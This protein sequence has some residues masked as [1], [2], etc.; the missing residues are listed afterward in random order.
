MCDKGDQRFHKLHCIRRKCENCGTDGLVAHYQEFAE[1]CGGLPVVYSKLERVKKLRKQKE[2]VQIMPVNHNTSITGLIIELA[3][4]LETLAEHIFVAT[5][6]QQQFANLL[7]EIPPSWV[8]LNMDFSENYSCIAQN[9]VQSAHWGH[10]QVTIHPT[11]AYYKCQHDNCTETVQEAL[12]F[13][14]SDLI[15]DSSAVMKFTAV[16]N[17]HLSQTRGITINRE[18]QLTDGCAAQY[19][20][21]TPFCDLSHAIEDFGFPIERHYY[22]SRHGKGPSDGAG[23]VVK[24]GTRR[25]VL[26][27]NVVINCAKDL[28]E[29]GKQKL[30]VGS[31]EHLHYKRSF[32][33]VE[34]I[35]H[36]RPIRSC[37]KTI[38]GTRKMHCVR[39][40]A[41][42]SFESR[43]LTCFCSTCINPGTG[44]CENASYVENWTIHDLQQNDRRVAENGGRG[45]RTA[46]NGRRG[47]RTAVNGRRG[48]TAAT[49]GGRGRR[50]APGGG[51]PAAVRGGTEPLAAAYKFNLL[52]PVYL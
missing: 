24:S 50:G 8:V 15:H 6:Q 38:K 46:V 26:G 16:A 20:S 52:P 23:A 34:D 21:K 44:E 30:T 43:N 11:V 42:F 3:K 5:W 4:D 2:V 1:R 29:F 9:E 19:K 48:R 17:E 41:P 51:E 22:G 40:L 12:I 36:D 25:A 39:T 7:K 49:R 47:G 31:D 35:Q 13:V 28:F 32:F 18:I 10:E 37:V 45:G 14:S 33:L 27:E